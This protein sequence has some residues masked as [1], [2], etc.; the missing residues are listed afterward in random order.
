MN[1][2]REF[3]ESE[4]AHEAENEK[5]EGSLMILCLI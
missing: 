4:D 2:E 5:V 3:R 1:R